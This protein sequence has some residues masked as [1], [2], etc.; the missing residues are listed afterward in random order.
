M[1]DRLIW[2]GYGSGSDLFYLAF[3][4]AKHDENAWAARS[5]IPFQFLFGNLPRFLKS[6]RS[7]VGTR[8]GLRC[9]LPT[10]LSISSNDG[11][12][13]SAVSA[14]P[15]ADGAQSCTLAYALIGIARRRALVARPFVVHVLAR[16][17]A[18]PEREHSPIVV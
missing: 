5:P 15:E 13:D 7:K 12:G 17:P 1:R 10:C 18:T 6:R 4:E 3:P 2:K 16:D 9:D 8:E 14:Q 11:L